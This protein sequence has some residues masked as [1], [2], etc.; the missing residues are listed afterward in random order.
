MPAPRQLTANR[1]GELLVEDPAACRRILGEVSGDDLPGLIF[2]SFCIGKQGGGKS[3]GVNEQVQ[4]S[5]KRGARKTPSIPR[6]NAPPDHAEGAAT[7]ELS[8]VTL[9]A[10]SGRARIPESLSAGA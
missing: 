2:A 4:K 6:C 5:P 7:A 8:M 10:T 9:V 1:A 3:G